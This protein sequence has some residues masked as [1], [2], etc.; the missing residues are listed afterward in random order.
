MQMN[1]EK[2]MLCKTVLKNG[3]NKGL[4]CLRKNCSLKHHNNIALFLNLPK[5]IVIWVEKRKHLFNYNILANTF[6][7]CSN[8]NDLSEEYKN[9]IIYIFNEFF[10][11][12]N[13]TQKLVLFIYIYKILDFALI[14]FVNRSS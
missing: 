8:E 11:T 3:P 14:I 1:C 7:Y 2:N 12:T 9:N 4:F 5:E 10:E 13:N 6:K